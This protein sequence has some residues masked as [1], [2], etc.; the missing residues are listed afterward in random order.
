MSTVARFQVSG[1]NFNG[2]KT[3]TVEIDRDTNM[4]RVR[5]SHFRQTYDLLLED[6]AE[7]IIYR[8]IKSDIAAKRNVRR[9]K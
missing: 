7:I 6:I 9:K 8:C 5:P 2:K 1:R 4:V 3:A